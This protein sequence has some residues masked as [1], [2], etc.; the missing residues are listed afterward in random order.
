MTTNCSTLPTHSLPPPTHTH[1]HTHTCAALGSAEEEAQQLQRAD[2]S[3]LNAGTE[4]EGVNA[5]GINRRAV[6]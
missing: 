2:I 5:D 4:L 1:S 3:K 6:K